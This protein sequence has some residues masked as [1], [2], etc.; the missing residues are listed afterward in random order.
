MEVFFDQLA[1]GTSTGALYALLALALVFI[2]RA[3]DIVNFAQGEMAMFSTY[4]GWSISRPLS[5]SWIPLLGIERHISILTWRPELLGIPLY[6][7]S[8]TEGLT[9]IGYFAVLLLT[10]GIAFIFGSLIERLIIRPSE[11]K[12]LLNAVI[13][14][15]GVFAILTSMA[16]FK[17]G[18]SPQTY[19]SPFHGDAVDFGLFKIGQHS[20]FSLIVAGVLMIVIY[21]FFQH[22]KVGLAVRA[23]ALNPQASKLM[24]IN[25][26][27]MLTLGWGL[28]AAVG[29]IAG[30]M[31]APSVS[32]ISPNLMLGVLLY[33]FAAA[34][35]GG[36]DSALGAVVGGLAVGI[37]QA[38]VVQYVGSEW[39]DL[40]AFGLIIAILMVK[41]T[42]LFG[43][44]AVKKV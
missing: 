6:G 35:L 8:E 11:G 15:L 20:L 31:V 38:M 10:A 42:G 41:P 34:V 5:F 36:L 44:P 4:L 43:E 29:C 7:G 37:G 24:G 40:V 16:N 28:A 18:A 19:P 25:T 13:V 33:G 17:Y 21:L 32:G 14:T 23:T 9:R 30:M 2:F 3:T 1:I 26:G 27:R 12:N 39:S 22:T